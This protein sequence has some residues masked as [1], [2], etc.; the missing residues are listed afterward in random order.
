MFVDAE[1][2]RI[3]YGNYLMTC[4]MLVCKIAVICPV[5]RTGDGDESTLKI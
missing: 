5:R 3:K 2:S 4:R 1:I